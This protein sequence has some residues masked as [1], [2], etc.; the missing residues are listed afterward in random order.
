MTQK[1]YEELTA[2]E[3]A[4]K[5]EGSIED[6]GFFADEIFSYSLDIMKNKTWVSGSHVMDI[7]EFLQCNSETIR[8]SARDH[9]KSFSFY[10]HVMWKIFRLFFVRESREIQYFSYNYSM[11]SYHTAKIKRAIM[12]NPF[13]DEILDNKTQAESIIS[14]KWREDGES[15]TVTPRG[16]MEFKRGI[17]SDDVY[18]DDPFQDPE[19]KLV[20]T[21]IMKINDIMKTQILDMYQQQLH[22]SGTAQT[23]NDFF[24]DQDF[25]HRFAVKIQPAIIDESKKRVLWKEWANYE[26]LMKKKKERGQ[27]IFNQEYLCSP[28]YSE[29]AY[30]KANDYDNCVNSN[31]KNYKIDEWEKLK[32]KRI[33]TD[34]EDTDIYAGYDIGKKVHPSHFVIYEMIDNKLIQRHSKWFDSVDYITQI[35]YIQ[36]YIDAFG[37]IQCFY[38]S[39]RG[40]LESLSEQ[41]EL[42]AEFEPVHFTFK[43]KHAMATQ[44]DKM[45]SG[46]LIEFLPEQ[47]QR[48]Q[49]LIVDNDLNAPETPE[50]HGDS[51]FSNCLAVHSSAQGVVDITVV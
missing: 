39:T 9:F 30:I 27:K 15:I 16:L 44:L 4:H 14:Y 18:V 50:G 8:V 24:F 11:A 45:I 25:T 17:H 20:P 22:V 43:K 32:E 1:P 21:K 23:Q 10:A 2:I 28:V 5:I 3:K 33:D 38:D 26:E 34:L 19:N 51:F 13:F 41:G 36:E 47:R 35:E 37:V 31:L 42:P 48:N 7:C 29:E 6:F 49:I 46:K 12:C 40:E